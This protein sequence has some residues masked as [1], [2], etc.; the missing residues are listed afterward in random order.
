M[1]GYQDS[2]NRAAGDNHHSAAIPE[3][4]REEYPVLSQVLGGIL[5]AKGETGGV[6]PATINFWF[7]GCELRFCI[8]PRLG[9]RVAFGVVASPEKGLAAFEAEL[10]AGRFGWK[11]AK[12]RRTA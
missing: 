11:P 3:S 7:E 2:W 5:V 9:N 6:P 1:S 4:F 10:A 12:N 8:M